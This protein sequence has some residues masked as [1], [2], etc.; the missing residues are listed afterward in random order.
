MALNIT[1]STSRNKR[2][3]NGC[4]PCLSSKVKCAENHPTCQRCA[5]LRIECEWPRPRP[6]LREIRRGWGPLKSRESFTPRPIL[7]LIE[8][9][10]ETVASRDLMQPRL[11]KDGTTSTATKHAQHEPCEIPSGQEGHLEVD[12][13]TSLNETSTVEQSLQ[14]QPIRG[15]PQAMWRLHTAALIPPV[16]ASHIPSSSSLIFE[17]PEHHALQHYQNVLS[18]SYGTKVSTWSTFT[19][20]LR[21]GRDHP[22]IMHFLLATSLAQLSQLS[23]SR[24]LWSSGKSHF[25]LGSQLLVSGMGNYEINH[26]TNMAAFWLVQFT[27][28]TIWGKKAIESMKKLSHAVA[29]YVEKHSILELYSSPDILQEMNPQAP[30]TYSK[31]LPLRER[32][33]LAR[34]MIWICYSD[35]EAEFCN[36]G[37]YFSDLLF[38][39]EDIAETIYHT[40]QNSLE[41]FYGSEYPYNE[42][43]DD[44]ERSSVLELHFQAA[45]VYYKI[46]KAARNSSSLG[47]FEAIE[48]QFGEMKKRYSSIFRLA[49]LNTPRSGRLV[50]TIDLILAHF[51]AVHIYNLRYLLPETRNLD[52]VE[53]LGVIVQD[54]LRITQRVII[55][56]STTVSTRLQWPLFM[57]G[58]ET[59]DK[60]Y[61]EWIM[62]KLAGCEYAKILPAALDAQE[63][64]EAKLSMDTIRNLCSQVC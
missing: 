10:P 26:C 50:K 37:G 28:R 53:K 19:V 17:A 34:F 6:S 61:L 7:P 11:E 62:Q 55:P 46:N 23:G 54:L 29:K 51:H 64:S 39:N 5:H 33:M 4:L 13:Q 8:Y 45:L 2:S 1:S 38:S 12:D 3:K 27:Y 57:A 20:I 30:T 18:K 42:V 16:S 22:T 14:F 58:I 63:G 56:R 41:L 35:L 52:T 24:D 44:V 15:R 60:I 31:P 49:E 40:S 48:G 9:P 36:A 32:S 59:N 25:Q 21:Y 43:I 47:Q